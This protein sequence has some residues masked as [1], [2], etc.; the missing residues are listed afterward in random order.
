MKKIIYL[1]ILCL[2]TSIFY[3]C[4]KDEPDTANSIFDTSAPELNSF[5]QWLRDNYVIPYN[6]QVKYKLED[7]E[8]DYAYNVIP[9]DLEKSKR[10][11]FLLKYLWIEA[12]KEVAGDGIH[13]VRANA[14]RVMHYLGSAEYDDRGK[15]LGVAEGGMKI[16][17]TEVNDLIPSQIIYQEFFNTIHHEFGHI[18]CQ[19][20]D[21]PIDFRTITPADY[22]PSTW[23]NRSDEEAAELGFVS[24][25]ASSLPEEDF[26][27]VLAR[28]ITYTPAEW[29]AKLTQAGT[30]GSELITIKLGRVKTYMKNAWK[31]DLDQ[32]K[33]VVQRRAY[34][35]QFIDLDNLG[36]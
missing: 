22:A 8:T 14:P 32:L 16:T 34:E 11:A 9:A 28:Y 35:I 29:Q 27:E 23:F 19:T 31:V 26:V 17:I 33:A 5:D 6:I 36:F 4:S 18:L 10:M 24:P 15:R 13:F 20:I 25:Y 7:I 12:Y 21:I 30:T 1:L 2:T 3:S